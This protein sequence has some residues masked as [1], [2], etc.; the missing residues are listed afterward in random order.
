[1]GRAQAMG[2][3]ATRP[4]EVQAEV[5]ERAETRR[6]ARG[7]PCYMQGDER[8]GLFGLVEGVLEV[9]MVEATGASPLIYLAR[10][11]WWFGALEIFTGRPRRFHM[12]ARTDC[13]ML[14]VPG[15]AVREIC[16]LAPDRW[17]AFAAL[18]CANWEGLADAVALM[19][20]PSPERRV[21][22]ALLI[23]HGF[24]PD[25]APSVAATRADVASI[26]NVSPRSAATALARLE[27]EGLLRRGYRTL[28]ILD[29]R[30]LARRAGLEA[31]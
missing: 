12:Q 24:Q 25:P 18:M 7:E 29:P 19:R 16:R 26:A 14:F 17:E 28:A 9:S 13:A 2:W 23:L 3:L 27:A 5:L 31:P 11:G 6:F 1:M 20:D 10:P 8:P 30:G 15:A 21:T 22:R 4:P